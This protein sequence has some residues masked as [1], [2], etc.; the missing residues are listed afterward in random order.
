MAREWLLA[1]VD[2]EDMKKT[3]ETA[4]PR[5][6]RQRWE[7]Y[8]YHHKW[9]TAV[10][11]FLVL[12]A[13]IFT[14]QALS[15][16]DPDYTILVATEKDHSTYTLGP[17]EQLLESY[18]RDLDGDGEVEVRL[19][20]CNLGANE[21]T[22]ASDQ[23]LNYQILQSH[24]VTGDVMLFAFEEKYY[25]WFMGEMSE[26]GTAFL[27]PLNVQG[28]GVSPDGCSWTWE[29][30]PRVTQNA[31]FKTLPQQLRFGVRVASG[32]AAGR[33]EEQQQCLEL[34]QAVI[35]DTPLVPTE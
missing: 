7:N 28:E 9:S 17:L 14:A 10:V 20:T 15:R 23:L 18:G 16:N 8:W 33:Q 21:Y 32:T 4:A 35:T 1:G 31:A 2:P 13:V 24:L 25:G 29:K 19:A 27:T 26:S 22:T 3:E 11:A 5:T 6:W 30:D 34:L 12:V